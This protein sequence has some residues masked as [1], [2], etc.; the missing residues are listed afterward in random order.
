M[1]SSSTVGGFGDAFTITITFALVIAFLALVF[2]FA[3]AV[4]TG[5]ASVVGLALVMV[6]GL[7]WVSGKAFAVMTGL[8]WVSVISYLVVAGLVW[9][10]WGAF[11]AVLVAGGLLVRGVMSVSRKVIAVVTR[12]VSVIALMS[13]A[14]LVWFSWNP[15]A[16]VTDMASTIWREWVIGLVLVIGLVSLAGVV[17]VLKRPRKSTL[18]QPASFTSNS[19]LAQVTPST[20]PVSPLRYKLFRLVDHPSLL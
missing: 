10:L 1:T 5:L 14:G 4:V 18:A 7:A 15:F 17:S 19:H 12:F 6:A 13:V 3:F 8:A 20:C 11:V 9:V 16:V 2:P